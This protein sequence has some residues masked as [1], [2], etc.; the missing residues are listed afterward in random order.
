[1]Q[2]T[3][4]NSLRPSK[5]TERQQIGALM[6]IVT[7]FQPKSAEFEAIGD[8]FKRESWAKVQPPYNYHCDRLG[9]RL[10]VSGTLWAMPNHDESDDEPTVNHDERKAEPT[11][12]RSP[13][14]AEPFAEYARKAVTQ[15]RSV[16]EVSE[17][18]GLTERA[19]QKRC[20]RGYYVARL[21][22]GDKGEQWQIDDSSIKARANATAGDDETQART[23]GEQQRIAGR[24]QCEPFAERGRTNGERCDRAQRCPAPAARRS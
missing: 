6:I 20:Q 16:Q 1:M 13:N 22:E 19:I 12:N 10:E 9:V 18:E 15:W 11:A 14:E 2:T 21:V 7:K 23:D 24:T 5:P 4:N 17:V 8:R 3:A